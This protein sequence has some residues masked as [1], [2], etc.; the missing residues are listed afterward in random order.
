ME[1]ERSCREGEYFVMM[2][3]RSG[4]PT[5]TNMPQNHNKAAKRNLAVKINLSLRG[6]RRETA[7]FFISNFVDE[8]DDVG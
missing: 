7:A 1:L 2:T 8:D 5:T 3:Y 4:A 6:C